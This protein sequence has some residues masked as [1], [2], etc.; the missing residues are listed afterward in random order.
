MDNRL[1][2]GATDFS[3][4][5]S[6]ASLFPKHERPQKPLL[7]GECVEAISWAVECDRG[8]LFGDEDFSDQCDVRY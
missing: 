7:G 4:I 1:R 5:I 2:R 3:P 8:V 6:V